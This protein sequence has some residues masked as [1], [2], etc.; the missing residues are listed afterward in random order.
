[1]KKI[2]I[3]LTSLLIFSS[4]QAE[5]N[6]KFFIEKALNQLSKVEIFLEASFCRALRYQEIKVA[7]HLLIV[8]IRVE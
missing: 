1:M 2:I 5:D 3:A 6:L 8:R 7:L 4:L